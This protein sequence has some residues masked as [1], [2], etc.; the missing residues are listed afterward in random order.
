MDLAFAAA[1]LPILRRGFY[2]PSLGLGPAS[3]VMAVLPAKQGLPVLQA[4]SLQVFR[5]GEATADPKLATLYV[6]D[7]PVGGAS[8]AFFRVTD[9]PVV[10]WFKTELLRG[11]FLVQVT[12]NGSPRLGLLRWPVLD[13]NTS[14][15]SYNL[16]EGQG[17]G[18]VTHPAT[19][20]AG[21]RVD[22]QRKIREVVVVERQADGQW[23]VAGAGFTAEDALQDVDLEV[24]DAG[25]WYA[26]GLDDWGELFEP[27]KAVSV[28]QRVRPTLMEG[29]LYEVTE[30]GNLPA[31]E[32]EWWPIQGENPSRQIG[33]ARAI[34]V[35]YYQP[36]G[37]GPFPVEMV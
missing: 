1:T 12:D 5:E 4:L 17:G 31:Q 14:A 26:L 19:V 25:T 6:G 36:L 30:A 15:L 21:A 10:Q 7:E 23:R 16:T 35:R 28:G 27:G 18:L 29:W 37:H 3:P 2:T 32:P 33:T 22:D 20:P 9:Q 24:T 8:F 34:A 11:Q 13:A